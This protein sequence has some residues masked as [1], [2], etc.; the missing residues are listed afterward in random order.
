MIP[1]GNISIIIK[2]LSAKNK[3]QKNKT[4]NKKTRELISA[5]VTSHEH[6]N[7]APSRLTVMGRNVRLVEFLYLAFTRMP[8]ESYR[9]SY[10]GATRAKVVV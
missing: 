5:P 8:G 2:W 9:E 1:D 7:K 6:N 10:R 4:K 3:K